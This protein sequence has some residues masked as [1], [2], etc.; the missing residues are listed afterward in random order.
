MKQESNIDNLFR[1]E[2]DTFSPDV[3]SQVW[4]NISNNIGNN[5]SSSSLSTSGSSSFGAGTIITIAVTCGIVGAVI[6]LLLNDSTI[7]TK[8]SYNN[9]SKQQSSIIEKK[10]ESSEIVFSSSEPIDNNDPIIISDNNNNNIK[11]IQ[12][13]EI[14][15]KQE[16]QINKKQP[17]SVVQLFLSDKK[18]INNNSSEIDNEKETHIEAEKIEIVELD[19]TELTTTIKSSYSGG[20]V[21]LVVSFEQSEN[22]DNVHWDF[23]DGSQAVGEVVEHIFREENDY[24]VV[25]TIKDNKGRNASSSKIINV[26]SRCIIT[27]IPNIFTPNSDGINDIFYVVGNNIKDY[28]IYIHD[29]SGELVYKSNDI[30]KGWNG[31]DLYGKTLDSGRYVYIIK[32]KGEDGTDLSSKGII[33]I[34]K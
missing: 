30:N 25:V 14:N 19:N 28:N 27:K 13:K 31:N 20:Y 24:N 16:K 17:S 21:P 15:A 12:I 2:F 9:K 11:N 1:E 32:A 26:K 8:T 3:N 34:S 5:L 33:T 18:T 10:Q 4:S 6:A 22:V 7:E 29:L 23:G